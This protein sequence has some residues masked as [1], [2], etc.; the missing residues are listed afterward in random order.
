MKKKF[1]AVALVSAIA[2]S[3]IA[4][5][6]TESAGEKKVTAAVESTAAESTSAADSSAAESTSVA[7]NT[8]KEEYQ[9]VSAEDAVK[10]AADGKTH[11][12]DVREWANYGVGRVA[13]SEWCPIFPLEDE[14]LADQ[15]KTYAE[16]NLKDGQNIY[17]ICNSGQRGAQKSTK[18]LEEAGIDAALIFTVEGGAKALAKVKGALT[19]NRAEEGINW[20]YVKAADVLGKKDAQI[21]DVRDNDTYAGGHL[22]NSLQVDLK[23]FESADA[24]AAMYELAAEKLNKDEPVYFLCYSGNKCAK[25][26]ISVLKDA[27]FD[28]KN[29]FIIENGAKD[30]DIQAAFVK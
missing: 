2:V 24:Q 4:G 23:E 9:F 1:L 20:Q 6:S 16:E 27:G 26:A 11:V 12:L 19:T 29:L 21:V 14:S 22:E 15:M 17:I 13:D 3:M 8:G 7:E 10:A 5:C 30:S 18:V 28:E 25:T